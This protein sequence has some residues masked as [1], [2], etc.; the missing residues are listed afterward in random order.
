MTPVRRLLLDLANAGLLMEVRRP[1]E[2]ASHRLETPAL[3][4]VN[5]EAHGEDE[6]PVVWT[7]PGGQRARLVIEVRWKIKVVR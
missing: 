2:P 1:A 4:A 3:L 6:K 7:P 5:A